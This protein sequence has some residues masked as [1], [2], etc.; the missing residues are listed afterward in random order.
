MNSEWTSR[1][2]PAINYNRTFG[3]ITVTNGT[4][5]AR[6]FE[7]SV[8]GSSWTSTPGAGNGRLI[9]EVTGTLSVGAS[10]SISMDAKG[11]HGGNASRSAGGSPTGP[12]SACPNGGG[13]C[14]HVDWYG[15]GG[16]YGTAGTAGTS[17]AGLTYGS[18]DF[19]TVLYLGSGGGSGGRQNGGYG[20]G[21]I[22]I[23]APNLTIA[24]GGQISAKGQTVGTYSGAGSGGT[25][26]LSVSGTFTNSGTISVAGGTAG[27]AGGTGRTQYP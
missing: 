10:G 6:G 3:S 7:N 13:G 26:V 25:I 1:P 14:G 18:I 11:Y 16:G 20:G 19:A 22:Q 4:L 9:L 8:S 12:G 23:V 17:A 2:A 27:R 24:S 15:G 21:A 5:S